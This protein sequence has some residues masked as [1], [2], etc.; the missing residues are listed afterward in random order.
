LRIK[1]L[2][3][4]CT[5]TDIKAYIKEY[6]IQTGIK[7][8][9]VLLDYLDLCMPT[10]VKVS[11]SDLFVK[12][13]YVTENMRDLAVDL[14]V[15]FV[16][17]SQLNR[18]SH[19]ELEFGHQHVSGGI[20]K[21]NTADNVIGIFTTNTMKENGRYQIQFMKTRSSAGVGSKVE[22]AFNNRTLR[23]Y[24]LEDGAESSA[25]TSSQ[26]IVNKLKQQSQVAEKDKEQKPNVLDKTNTLLDIMQTLKR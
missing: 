20:S 23:I 17:A 5:A 25:T 18:Q 8:D 1:Q 14:Q 24:D 2:K 11:P 21:I 9:A 16:T 19:E 4:G 12:D 15:L 22:L 7:V 3:N 13:K 6:E 26:S 10:N